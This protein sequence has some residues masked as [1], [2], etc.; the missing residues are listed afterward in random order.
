VPSS[1]SPGDDRHDPPEEVIPIL[2]LLALVVIGT[3]TSIVRDTALFF[4]FS[5]LPATVPVAAADP[6]GRLPPTADP[7]REG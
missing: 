2:I 4:A 7:P 1:C 6:R 3:G 5:T